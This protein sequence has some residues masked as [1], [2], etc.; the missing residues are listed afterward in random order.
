MTVQQSADEM[1]REGEF[2]KC[3]LL[4]FKMAWLKPFIHRPLLAR[5]LEN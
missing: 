5:Y 2:K 4:P 3:H 1:T